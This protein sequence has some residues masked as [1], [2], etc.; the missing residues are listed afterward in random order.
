MPSCG[1]R[2]R[3]FSYCFCCCYFEISV[4][5]NNKNSLLFIDTSTLDSQIMGGLEPLVR[6]TNKGVGTFCY[7]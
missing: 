7:I 3:P 5:K 2:L 1:I 4:I 6:I